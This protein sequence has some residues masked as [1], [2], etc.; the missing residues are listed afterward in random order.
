MKYLEVHR[1]RFGNRLNSTRLAY[2]VLDIDIALLVKILPKNPTETG[3]LLYSNSLFRSTKGYPKI[4][5]Y[6]IPKMPS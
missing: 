3:A 2:N 5:K 1:T 4:P 6:Q